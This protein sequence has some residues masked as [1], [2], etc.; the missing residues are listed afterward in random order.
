MEQPMQQN[1]RRGHYQNDKST[2]SKIMITSVPKEIVITTF[3]NDPF[4]G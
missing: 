3:L 2:G 1:K 4:T